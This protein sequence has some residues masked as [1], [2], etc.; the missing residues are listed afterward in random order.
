[1][2]WSSPFA[3][4]SGRA[5]VIDM[6]ANGVWKGIYQYKNTPAAYWRWTVYLVALVFLRNIKSVQT[7]K[8]H[9]SVLWQ[10]C[11]SYRLDSEQ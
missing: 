8:A 4:A 6:N 1:M 10:Y 11:R 9:T 7:R 2:S 5:L 3:I